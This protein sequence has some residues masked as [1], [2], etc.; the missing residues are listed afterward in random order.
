[1][2]IE[3]LKSQNLFV[4]LAITGGGTNILDG[5]CNECGLSEVF[6]GATIPY[7]KEDFLRFIN[8]NGFKDK[9][10]SIYAARALALES[11][12]RA[13]SSNSNFKTSI[14]IGIACSIATAQE[15]PD[16]RHK[17]NI[18]IHSS[19]LSL[20]YSINLGQYRNR[21]EENN[22]IK[23]STDYCIYLFNYLLS[24]KDAKNKPLLEKQNKIIL[25]SDESQCLKYKYNEDIVLKKIDIEENKNISIIPGS[26]NPIHSMHLHM[27]FMEKAK[28]NNVFFELSLNNADKGSIT[29]V[30]L[31]DR[32]NEL[33]K[34]DFLISNNKLFVDKY[35]NLRNIYKNNNISFVLGSDTFLRVFDEKYGYSIK[36]LNTVFSKDNNVRFIVY[37]RSQ[38]HKN[39]IDYIS[40]SIKDVDVEINNTYKEISSTSL[41]NND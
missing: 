12:K 30:D 17:I 25:Y 37:M 24:N 27:Y 6:A 15:R 39:E 34:Y 36:D 5:I 19:E 23:N 35:I 26:F 14:G 32:L 16:R 28:G 38:H 29:Y 1:M 22:L 13:F 10:S 11:F 20:E 3:F 2:N 9:F 40:Q 31:E 21:I 8:N 33:S 7:S 4:Y 18:V 41:R